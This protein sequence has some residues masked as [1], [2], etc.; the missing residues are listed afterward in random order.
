MKK[1]IIFS[2][3]PIFLFITRGGAADTAATGGR[4][5]IIENALEY[6]SQQPKMRKP[7]GANKI[8][9]QKL[10]REGSDAFKNNDVKRAISL[11]EQ[12][13]TI[14]PKYAE[15]YYR[16]GVIYVHQGDADRAVGYFS[17][18]IEIDPNFTQAYTNMGSILAQLKKYPQAMA[19]YEK[20][21]SLDNENPK[22]YYNIGL[23]YAAIGRKDSA[24]PY[25]A[26]AKQLSLA[27]KNTRLLEEI[28]RVYKD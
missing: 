9:A 18:T 20:A 11:L 14:D 26:R 10:L 17:K 24:K 12:S 23:I 13:V 21:L 8:K 22:I 3:L 7:M 28:E 19:Y 25:F 27:Q 15:A 1:L 4:D 6:F 2:L 5:E 16:L